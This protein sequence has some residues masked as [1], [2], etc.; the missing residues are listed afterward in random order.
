M[1]PSA[2]A[3]PPTQTAQRV[4]SAVS[5]SGRA[6]AAATAASGRRRPGR[7]GLQGPAGSC[8]GFRPLRPQ[9]FPAG[10]PAPFRGRVAQRFRDARWRHLDGRCTRRQALA[11][12]AALAQRAEL[13]L[14]QRR[15]TCCR[16]RARAARRSRDQD[17]TLEHRLP[18]PRPPRPRRQR[19][20]P[21]AAAAPSCRALGRCRRPCGVVAL[22]A[23]PGSPPAP[24]GSL[25]AA[26]LVDM[27]REEKAG[28]P[29]SVVELGRARR[30]GA[31]AAQQ[32]S[33][34]SQQ[35]CPHGAPAARDTAR[36]D[37]GD[38]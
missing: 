26:R 33:R 35:P 17:Q 34:Q 36:P 24:R 29:E 22:R 13:A 20:H 28:Q 19:A 27:A 25:D 18:H 6:G 32:E 16:R 12:H 10:A 23:P 31:D 14:E 8:S 2:S 11:R 15:R 38:T 4:P 7:R 3:M 1:P 9:P 21:S 5:M 30:A 37:F